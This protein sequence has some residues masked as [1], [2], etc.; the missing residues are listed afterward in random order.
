MSL[1]D[2]KVEITKEEYERL[3]NLDYREVQEYGEALQ[4]KTMFPSNGY[5]YYGSVLGQF[6]G[7]YYITY[8][9]GSSAD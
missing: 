6:N 2:V 7:K 4:N 3:C 9:R 5:G 8:T 1:V